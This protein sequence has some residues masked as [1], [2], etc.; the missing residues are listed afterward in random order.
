MTEFLGTL[1]DAHLVGIGTCLGSHTLFK[2]GLGIPYHLT[3]K[4]GKLCSMLGF[5]K[6]ITLESLGYF[7]ITLTVGLTRHCKI[8][9]HLGALA[10]EVSGKV[11]D[12]LVVRTLGCTDFML[13]YKLEKSGFVEFL[14]LAA[15]SAALGALFR[16]F[17]TFMNITAHGTNKFLF[18][19]LLV[20]K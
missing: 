11:L 7:G 8:H 14:E 13:G 19:F 17:I 9:T 10:V 5:L 12:H 20:I 15:G 6:S 1:C 4:F 16:S 2:V 3:E 18:H